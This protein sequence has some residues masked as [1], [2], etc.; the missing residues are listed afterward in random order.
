MRLSMVAEGKY[1]SSDPNNDDFSTELSDTGDWETM[2]ID[3]FLSLYG[4]D[5]FVD[6]DDS[7]ELLEEFDKET[8]LEILGLED[9]GE[10]ITLP[11]DDDETELEQFAEWNQLVS[12]QS[13]DQGIDKGIEDLE[14]ALLVGVVPADALVGSGVLPG[15]DG[16]DPLDLSTKDYFKQVQSFILSLVPERKY[17]IGEDEVPEQEPEAGAA[18]P[19]FGFVGEEER[20]PALILRDYREAE[21]RHGRLAMLAAVIW[22]LQEIADRIFIPESFGSMTIIYGG[23]TL[24]VA[25]LLMT[26]FM[27]N[28]GY[29][30]IYSSE[31]KENESGDAFLPGECFWDPLAI[32]E[33][34]P[35]SMKRNMQEREILNG[36]A[37]MIAVAAYIFEEGMSHKPVISLAANDLLFEPFFLVPF[38][39]AWLDTQFGSV[40]YIDPGI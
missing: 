23:P 37:S 33:G 4:D 16:W 25:P 38:V 6:I 40:S 30:D 3:E 35:D 34:A 26:F 12:T 39:Q 15:D 1:E 7:E 32:M 11:E 24:P 18:M 17:R 20:P 2:D 21:I 36:R 22:P 29:L 8:L 28:L 10:T 13:I 19:T 9:D 27:L 14:K 31:I 5:D